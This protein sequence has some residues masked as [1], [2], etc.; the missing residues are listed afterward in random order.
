MQVSRKFIAALKINSKPAYQIAWE[1]GIH[2]TLLS[3]LLHGC[4]RIK[5]NDE[6]II[7]VGEILGL[8]PEEC[9]ESASTS[10]ARESELS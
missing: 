2:P 10:P 6:R 7:A 1:A 3:K 9:F 5:L 8:K 4:E